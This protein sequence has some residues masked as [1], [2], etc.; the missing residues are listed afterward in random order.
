LPIGGSHTKPARRNRKL[1]AASASNAYERPKY[2]FWLKKERFKEELD[3]TGQN[4]DH[5]KMLLSV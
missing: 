3:G 5:F 2:A 1:G 4:L